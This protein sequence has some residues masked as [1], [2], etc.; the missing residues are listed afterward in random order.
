M[1][2]IALAC[3]AACLPLCAQTAAPPKSTEAERRDYFLSHYTKYEYRIPMRDGARLFTAVYVPKDTSKTYPVLLIRTPYTVSPYGADNYTAFSASLE[4]FMREGFI[5]AYQDVRGRIKSE[6]RFVNVRPYIPVKHGPGDVDESTDAYDTIDWLVKHA[7]NNNGNVGIWGISYPGFYAAMAAIDAHPA[8]KA[9]SPQAPIADWFLGDDW[10]HNGALF[11]AHTFNFL[12]S[13]GRPW[14]EPGGM[15]PPR[16]DAGTPDGYDYLL[17]LGPLRNIDPALFGTQADF[18]KEVLEHDR[19]DEFWKARATPPHLKNLR[20]AM[21]W[22]GGWFDAEDL[23]GPLASYRAA[24][25]QSPGAVNT[26]VMG[27]WSHGGWMREG[28]RLGDV[29][30]NSETSEFFRDEI[31]LPFFAHYLKDKADPK[32][33]EAY[34]FETGRNQWRRHDAWPPKA[35]AARTLYFG[36]GGKLKFEPPRG[37]GF[38][39]YVSDPARPVPF[40][41]E[42]HPGMTYNYMTSD[43]RFA[44]RRTDVVVYQT[45]PLEEDMT[46]AGPV[47]CDLRVSTTGTDSDWVVKLID[48]YPGNYPDPHPNP[49]E[50]RMGGYQQ[51]VRGEPFR[52]RYRNGFENPAAFEPG[53][54]TQVKFTMPDIYHSFRSGH[55]V[56]VQVQSSW[57]PLVDRNPQKFVRLSEAVESDF[58]KATQRV[59]RAAD[60]PSSIE[61]SVLP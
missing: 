43:Q 22:V 8:L 38:D 35:A 53:K 17:G 47:R 46:L 40:T 15:P 52:G 14:R 23:L 60:A 57:F 32:L 2:R 37:A 13:F 39:E 42:V 48:V 7:L 11:L 24:E 29:R 6:G 18:W 41:G 56:M 44:A 59:Y 10:R 33:P 1:W 50:V 20:P 12:V 5:F 61:V 30:F 49:T 26:L 16:F 25:R 4:K 31:M 51:L 21:L 28:D 19:Y 45:E 36:A 55:R 34:V 27:P 54:V 9:A 3:F 58:Q